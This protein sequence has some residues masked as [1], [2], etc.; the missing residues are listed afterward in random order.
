MKKVLTTALI[1]ALVCLGSCC[2]RPNLTSL[3]NPFLGTETML[4]SVEL[5]FKPTWR[6]WGA[7]TF[8]GSAL[9]NAMVQLSPVTKFR[10]G[11]GYQ[12]E[13]STILGF[14]HT[15]KGHWNLNHIPIMPVDESASIDDYGSIF[16]HDSE[17]AHPGYYHVSLDRYGVDVD[18]TSTLRCGVHRYDFKNRPDTELVLINLPRSNERVRHFDIAQDGPRALVGCQNTGYNVYFRIES[19]HEILLLD[20][21]TKDNGGI[22]A[23][24]P[25]AAGAG[26]PRKYS[27]P[28]PRVGFAPDGKT[29]LELRI[30]LS[31]VSPEGAK[32][33]MDAELKD[34]SFETV[35]KEADQTWEAL[36]SKIKVSGGTP[37]QRETFYSTFYRSMLWPCLRSDANGD[38]LSDEG[39]VKNTAGHHYY[40]DPSYWD[41]YRNKLVLLEM[42]R[43]DVACDV[44]RSS[45]DRGLASGFMPNFF[46]GDHAATFVAGA[47]RRGLRD[48]DIRQS[49]EL[50]VKN[51]TIEG[52]ARPYLDEYISQGWIS[53]VEVD[54]A[55]T[56][57]PAKASV[58]KTEEYSYD[59]YSVA[60]LAKELGDTATYSLLMPR[61]LNYRNLFNPS[62]GLFQ[63]RL[64]SGEWVRNFDP[65]YPYFH[66][67]YREATGWMSSFFAPHDTEGL[68][69]LYGG[70][71]A[72]EE[73]LDSLYTIPWKGYEAHNLSGFI[74]QY[75]HGNQPDHTCPFLYYFIGKGEKSQAVIDHLLNKFYHLGRHGLAYAGM[76]DAGEMSSWYVLSAIGL[77]SYSPA[78]P[79]YLV[80]VPLFDKVRFSLGESEFT[81]VKSGKGRH[82]VAASYDG[83]PL[84]GLFV[85]HE[86]L[87]QGKELL[88]EC[89]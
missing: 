61:T 26:R 27:R 78:D 41:D 55:R 4:D 53:E 80:T 82:K 88:I 64:Q 33:N 77:Y 74:G 32:A 31:F 51:A 73:K 45:T 16:S 11:S 89:E 43:P 85:S 40:T 49:Y 48:F 75:C 70:A 10:S 23:D 2:Q 47:Y 24:D 54:K 50:L 62:R 76:D 3:V 42:I 8:P 72:F 60:M 25:V 81:I 69:E 63:G 59:D 38:F 79:E 12:Y 34:K 56:D 15:S 13:D 18:L 19:N 68:I 1:A 52:P 20:S 30:A 9:P 39:T 21:L 17:E 67:Q 36:L 35:R 87:L 65:Y 84:E 37:E 83:Q 57:T 58:T 7:E 46:H 44:I 28:I 5:G 14:S 22:I 6:T 29:T 66:Y 86:Q 71:D